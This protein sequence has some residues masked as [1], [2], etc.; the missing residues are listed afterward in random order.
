MAANDTQK[1]EHLTGVYE[2][3]L[4]TTTANGLINF[5]GAVQMTSKILVCCSRIVSCLPQ[6]EQKYF[7]GTPGS[8]TPP[9]P[10]SRKVKSVN[11]FHEIAGKTSN[12]GC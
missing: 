8:G 6:P 9:L 11:K 4:N 2:A 3:D 12:S 10:K 1:W 7:P 5:F